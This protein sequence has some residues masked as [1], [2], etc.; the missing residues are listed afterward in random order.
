MHSITNLTI[1]FILIFIEPLFGLSFNQPRFC[2]NA[3]WNSNGTTFASSSTIGN[4]PWDIFITTN[5]DIYVP[6]RDAGTILVWVNASLTLTD[7]IIINSTRIFSTFAA[8][9]N[10]LFFSFEINSTYN[11]VGKVMSNMSSYVVVFECSSICYDVFIDI[12]NSI[13]CSMSGEHRIIKKSSNSVKI[14]A[15]TGVADS[16]SYT[17]NAPNDIFV[18]TNFDLYVAD[19]ANNRI[20]LFQSGQSQAITVA[21]SGS[22]NQTIL[23]NRPTSIV[24]DDNKYLFIVEYDGSRIIRSGPNGFECLVGGNGIGSLPNQ[25]RIPRS[26]SFDSFGNIFV[27]DDNNH[28]I[29]KFSLMTNSCQTIPS[30]HLLSN[31]NFNSELIAVDASNNISYNQPKFDPYTVWSTTAITFADINIIGLRPGGIFIDINDTIYVA[32]QTNSRIQIWMNNSINPIA[33]IYGKLKSPKSIFVTFHGDIL[34]DNRQPQFQVN[35]L[36]LNTNTSAIVMYME[37]GCYDLFVDINN[38]L[39]CSIHYRPKI[40]TKS[41]SSTSNILTIVAGTGC[42]GSTSTTL[43]QPTGIFVDENFDL[44]VADSQ[45]GR[46]QL[47]RSGASSAITVAGYS[48]ANVTITL[49]Y[50]TD[51][52][53]DKDKNIFIVDFG[54][55][56]IVASGMNGFRCIAGCNGTYGSASN[57]LYNPTTMAFDS[58]GNIFVVDQSNNRIQKFLRLNN[59]LSNFLSYNQPKFCSNI[60]WQSNATTFANES[61]VGL[62]PR[63]IFINTNNIIYMVHT[64]N[65]QLSIWFNNSVITTLITLNGN[66][67]S[68]KSIFALMNDDIYVDNG[69]IN[70]RIDKFTSNTNTSTVVMSV[71][72]NCQGLF[73]DISNNLYCAV[74]TAHCVYKKW[75]DDNSTIMIIAAGTG[76]AG[77]NSTMLHDPNGIFV[78]INFDLYVADY[79][80]HRIQCFHLGQSE[81]ITVAGGA[82]SLST[83]TLY[84]PS[85]VILDGNKYI[86]IA[87]TGNN[88][89]IGSDQHGFRCI[90]GCLNMS[91]SENDRLSEPRGIYFD[92]LGNLYVADEVN[93][94]IQKFLS[95]SI[96]CGKFTNMCLNLNI[97][98]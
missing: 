16:T 54:K 42:D 21:G 65:G 58:Y 6:N 35:Q 1:W 9:D 23:L 36:S 28:R 59:N 43:R 91:G 81:G 53:L 5:N 87:D 10:S 14:I 83:I 8:E 27:A 61:I 25:L 60:S 78:D 79:S 45:N 18:D 34:T 56:R 20:Q 67:S 13:Y 50:P 55:H 85:G 26:M 44:Y 82:L 51:I 88:R 90:V 71:P 11:A 69:L 2:S 4:Y 74:D 47:F 80:N 95:L 48:S 52:V 24:L 84:R 57:E 68:T 17:L 30:S 94:R 96:L 12:D 40:V 98:R 70:R 49:D 89:I 46:I 73:I 63:G 72:S 19:T 76:S 37:D 32:D 33:T 62:N 41:L 66:I 39:Y 22:L 92:T 38:T 3:T 75:L 64:K 97:R 29:Q 77:S 15:G 7:R 86:F 93:H 31:N